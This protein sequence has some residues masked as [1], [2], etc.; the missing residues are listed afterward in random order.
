VRAFLPVW[1]QK[2]FGAWTTYGGGGYWINP[3]AGNRDTWFA[4][5]QLQVHATSFLTPGVELY[6]Q[7]APANDRVS[8]VHFNAGLILDIGESH[9]VLFSAG[10]AFHGCDCS[11]AYAAYL[12]T[13]GPCP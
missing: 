4:G 7:T 12:V 10:R 13:F 5:W 2:S 3:G 9:H 11:H 1:V 8:E 6:Y